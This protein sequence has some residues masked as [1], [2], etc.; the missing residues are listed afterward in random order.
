MNGDP[1]MSNVKISPATK[2]RV[3][4]RKIAV[5]NGWEFEQLA[6]NPRVDR[7]TKGKTVVD[8]THGPSNLITTAEKLDGKELVPAPS[9]GKMFTVQAWLTGIADPDHSRSIR[10]S[11]EQAAANESGQGL[12]KIVTPAVGDP[13]PKP[14]KATAPS[15]A[16]AVKAVTEVKAEA[17]KPTPR[18]APRAAK[19]APAAASA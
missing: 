8:V 15:K 16:R 17:P 7:F 14:V 6:D 13:E 9:N 2:Y 5:A 4:I 3:E 18:P 19:K 1:V 10:L 12:A 11:R